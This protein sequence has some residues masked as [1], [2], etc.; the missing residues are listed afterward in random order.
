MMSF[1]AKLGRCDVVNVTVIGIARD[2]LVRPKKC[3][4]SIWLC[5]ILAIS[6]SSIDAY[7]DPKEKKEIN[8]EVAA[9]LTAFGETV[10]QYLRFWSPKEQLPVKDPVCEEL[11]G[12]V[13]LGVFDKLSPLPQQVQNYIR[14]TYKD[15]GVLWEFAPPCSG[16]DPSVERIA[17][18]AGELAKAAASY[19]YA[20]EARRDGETGQQSA[21]C[22]PGEMG[23]RCEFE[24]LD[25]PS[26]SEWLSKPKTLRLKSGLS[27]CEI[28]ESFLSVS[29]LH[30]QTTLV[31]LASFWHQAVSAA[32]DVRS[33]EDDEYVEM[34]DHD[35]KRDALVR[36]DSTR[37]LKS[38]QRALLPYSQWINSRDL[39][40]GLS[41][42]N[43]DNCTVQTSQESRDDIHACLNYA[44][45]LHPTGEEGTEQL[46]RLPDSN[47]CRNLDNPEDANFYNCSLRRDFFVSLRTAHLTGYFAKKL[48]LA[49]QNASM[50]SEAD[51]TQ[52]LQLAVSV[53]RLTPAARS[54]LP[55]DVT[56]V[57]SFSKANGE[58]LD[59]LGGND[60]IISQLKASLKAKNGLST[61][62]ENPCTPVFSYDPYW[63]DQKSQPTEPPSEK[64]YTD[65]RDWLTE[66][67]KRLDREIE[68]L[69]SVLLK[70]K[71]QYDT[72][73]DMLSVAAG[74]TAAKQELKG[75][76][77]AERAAMGLFLKT[78]AAETADTL[79]QRLGSPTEC[80][81]G[82]LDASPCQMVLHD[83]KGNPT[84]V[85]AM[86]LALQVFPAQDY[87]SAYNVSTRQL[88]TV[89]LTDDG[90]GNYAT[91][92][93]VAESRTP[94][95]V[96][97]VRGAEI[98]K[99]ITPF[100]SH[101]WGLKVIGVRAQQAGPAKCKLQ[102][103]LKRSG[104]SADSN[105]LCRAGH[106]PM[107]L[108]ADERTVWQRP[109]DPGR[110]S[111]WL[112]YLGAN[113]F[114]S[115]DGIGVTW[116]QN[117][118]ELQLFGTF[119]AT[120]LGS[121]EF[122]SFRLSLTKSSESD[123]RRIVRQASLRAV[124][125]ALPALSDVH[126]QSN[127]VPSLLNLPSGMVFGALSLDSVKPIRLRLYAHPEGHPALITAFV[128]TLDRTGSLIWRE[129][130]ALLTDKLVL[131]A[132]TVNVEAIRDLARVFTRAAGT[133][134]DLRRREQNLLGDT[135]ARRD[136]FEATFLALASALSDS[137]KD[138]TDTQSAPVDVQSTLDRYRS[139]AKA[140]QQDSAATVLLAWRASRENYKVVLDALRV[141]LE[142][143]L[144]G[145]LVVPKIPLAESLAGL[146]DTTKD[147]INKELLWLFGLSNWDEANEHINDQLAVLI[148]E[149][150]Q[151]FS[152]SGG[153]FQCWAANQEE[154]T[155]NEVGR[156][157]LC[158][159][160]QE[161]VNRIGT[162]I[163]QRFVLGFQLTSSEYDEEVER[164]RDRLNKPPA[165]LTTQQLLDAAHKIRL[166]VK[167]EAERSI[168]EA[169]AATVADIGP[170][171]GGVVGPLLTALK[172]ET[173]SADMLAALTELQINCQTSPLGCE[174][175]LVS[176]A[177]DSLYPDQ[178]AVL[179]SGLAPHLER[180][181]EALIP[182]PDVVYGAGV[183]VLTNDSRAL[184]KILTNAQSEL[185]AVLQ[186]AQQDYLRKIGNVVD[187]AGLV[188]RETIAFVPPVEVR[189]G[190]LYLR[191]S[192]SAWGGEE[193]DKLLGVNCQPDGTNCVVN[194]ENLRTDEN[195][196]TAL[197]AD[198][199]TSEA[200]SP[201][202][203]VERAGVELTLTLPRTTSYRM[204]I[205]PK[206]PGLDPSHIADVAQLVESVDPRNPAVVQENI[207]QAEIKHALLTATIGRLNEA[208]QFD[209]RTAYEDEFEAF[210]NACKAATK[211]YFLFGDSACEDPI[212]LFRK[213]SDLDLRQISTELIKN[214]ANRTTSLPRPTCTPNHKVHEV[215]QDAAKAACDELAEQVGEIEDKLISN[216]PAVARAKVAA[217]PQAV[218]QAF[219]KA[220]AGATQKEVLAT[221]L[222]VA[223]AAELLPLQQTAF[224]FKAQTER[225]CVD[226]LE[227][228]GGSVTPS[229]GGLKQRYIDA[230]NLDL[231]QIANEQVSQALKRACV[232]ASHEV[233]LGNVSNCKDLKAGLKQASTDEVKKSL[234]DFKLVRPDCSP[235]KHVGPI[236][237]SAAQSACNVLIAQL[238][239]VELAVL[240]AHFQ[241]AQN[242]TDALPRVV[243]EAFGD[244]LKQ[245]ALQAVDEAQ[246]AAQAAA[247]QA[248]HD[249]SPYWKEVQEYEQRANHLCVTTRDRAA[250]ILGDELP[251]VDGCKGIDAVLAPDVIEN[252]LHKRSKEIQQASRD[253]VETELNTRAKP[254]ID[255]AQAA[256]NEQKKLLQDAAKNQAA[257]VLAELREAESRL[258]RA[259]DKL[260]S[261][262]DTARL[263]M[264]N[265][266][267]FT[268]R[269]PRAPDAPCV[270][271]DL[272]LKT[273]MN[274]LGQIVEVTGGLSLNTDRLRDDALLDQLE[275]G[276]F[277][278]ASL[279]D[280]DWRKFRTDPS[281]ET[282]LT[283]K[284]RTL[285]KGL[286]LQRLVAGADKIQVG[287]QYQPAVL[288]FAVP[289]NTEM[290]VKGVKVELGD[291]GPTITQAVC[292]EIR[293][294]ILLEQPEILPDARIVR[295]LPAYC[296]KR[297]LKGL[298]F[299]VAVDLAEGIGRVDVQVFVDIET[300]VRIVP[301]DFKQLAA[302]QL[303]TL[304]GIDAVRPVAPFYDSTDGL[305]LYLEG[306]ADT[307]LGLALQAG[308]SVSPRRLKFR[309]PIGLRIP[310]W[311]DASV[312]SL[313][314]LGITYNPE[315]KELSLLGAL[316]VAPGEAMNNLVR[317]DGRGTVGLKEQK[318]E[319]TGNLVVLRLLGVAGTR[320]TII[321]PERLFEHT[322]GTSPMLA[323][324]V[325]LQGELHIQD[326][327]PHPFL[328]ASGEGGI[329]GADIATMEV[330][331]QRN[332]GGHFDAGLRIPLDESAVT[333]NVVVEENMGDVTAGAKT[334]LRVG[335]VKP[336]FSMDANTRSVGIGMQVEAEKIG[337]IDIGFALP[338]FASLTPE[339]VLSLLL[340][341][342]L[343]FHIPSSL[344]TVAND[345]PE[346]YSGSKSGSGGQSQG[347]KADNERQDPEPPIG[348]Y[349]PA[350]R[351][352]PVEY[353]K[354]FKIGIKLWC[355]KRIRWEP[356]FVEG[357]GGSM[358]QQAGYSASTAKHYDVHYNTTID[359]YDLLVGT[360][361]GDK[362]AYVF[363]KNGGQ[364]WA[365]T[366]RANKLAD[367]NSRPYAHKSRQGKNLL[368]VKTGGE[369]FGIQSE[370]GDLDLTNENNKLKGAKSWLQGNNNAGGFAR[371]LLP[372]V[373]EE[374][375]YHER[376]V[377][378]KPIGRPDKWVLL[379][380]TKKGDSLPSAHILAQTRG[381][382]KPL[383]FVALADLNKGMGNSTENL[384]LH[385]KALQSKLPDR[386]DQVCPPR[387]PMQDTESSLGS[388]C[389]YLAVGRWID[390]PVAL[391]L[392]DT[393]GDGPTALLATRS[394]AW[395]VPVHWPK[396]FSAASLVD[397][398]PAMLLNLM[399]SLARDPDQLDG[400]TGLTS[401]VIDLSGNG[402]IAVMGSQGDQEMLLFSPRNIQ[403]NQD[404]TPQ[405]FAPRRLNMACVEEFWA[406]KGS[407]LR[408]YEE[409]LRAERVSEKDALMLALIHHDVFKQYGFAADPVG[410]LYRKCN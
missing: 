169:W 83:S 244:T 114:V 308:F 207:Q 60:G 17:I 339:Y 77:F 280:L 47:T 98:D 370:G 310:G 233:E 396:R 172:D 111:E 260:F 342:G 82:R 347:R 41:S 305:T 237:T 372:S 80:K 97:F 246:L 364:L 1:N 189:D 181:L 160:P 369:Y 153:L 206:I 225:L 31:N 236:L 192:W 392:D 195:L 68:F 55:L 358:A 276:E 89:R 6:F 279:V 306:K 163:A 184:A 5:L 94:A 324:I 301:P 208:V 393:H 234:E 131:Y 375:I 377:E 34:S 380:I 161:A 378:Q 387:D 32:T 331:L 127:S 128:G 144:M 86:R 139:Y 348:D 404:G 316:T 340:D 382:E 353:C 329:F 334:D 245:Q 263:E 222:N 117:N 229:C 307:P 58:F 217:L 175:V 292:Q 18:I 243:A 303:L 296:I 71:K 240:D 107:M 91:P 104:D 238:D 56:K 66:S 232:E 200:P 356:A 266:A 376:T 293:D 321:L 54:W 197:S 220:F 320:T 43:L 203:R 2:K 173:N 389:A 154:N 231:R 30:E 106:A 150:L 386:L 16:I 27:R 120:A 122:E 125:K 360:E 410:S 337:S 291:L 182:R 204:A 23:K 183:E 241:R 37:R 20:L 212:A 134:E 395:V 398:D 344:A 361:A 87:D 59:A 141:D 368:V 274:L 50:Q 221:V 84:S 322:I 219:G 349:K 210:E 302:G 136:L 167:K 333:F 252:L 315:N 179:T 147:K 285:D 327:K 164:F 40:E 216:N 146:E 314:N 213:A 72:A 193:G 170:D 123:W 8:S 14:D 187:T 101:D 116:D 262:G 400:M 270:P 278:P 149:A 330:E 256:Y 188:V 124:L 309:G 13:W 151:S 199:L 38:F 251:A 319:V 132:G 176:L 338:S 374:Q 313:G 223:S 95:S 336:T 399:G 88:V 261:E 155:G 100:E 388:P 159:A 62:D 351:M 345:A 102:D 15:A 265:G 384:A 385:L 33:S 156:E 273:Q 105:R 282:V 108:R 275:A 75:R 226:A 367:L 29:C 115:A 158:G 121:S 180:T 359:N 90:C 49:Q 390:K 19:E 362:R 78:R 110:A 205:V 228:L 383:T 397:V 281:L 366:Y 26:G 36:A 401:A 174:R 317:V 230:L 168:N 191:N 381:A 290:S 46:V 242:L 312:V 335:P 235:R 287:L 343:T 138:V 311:Y 289:V 318:L 300:G 264:I 39:I 373:A 190:A 9:E 45:E 357:R 44:R 24:L 277:N 135:L 74:T 355:E 269:R 92:C 363:A 198:S 283:K 79:Y 73:R 42:L 171:A 332:F 81:M 257:P 22:A 371:R 152:A 227:S 99:N 354:P 70:Q 53:A 93:Y 271:H 140:L 57:D 284:L 325:K 326:L 394:Q 209:W 7:G 258:C 143:R 298:E 328:K 407:P 406:G 350:W 267:P 268:I 162:Q 28:S 165:P 272:S 21:V 177:L 129:P 408:P 403:T 250:D 295:V 157:T 11:T 178:A 215:L 35:M 259:I 12:K 4:M 148:V 211:A 323:D 63:I 341:M 196:K 304:F 218:T 130:R 405:Y 69:Q 64:N 48:L 103:V 255:A 51:R 365:G 286:T 145:N 118:N 52:V 253:H 391:G 224:E 76:S 214:I 352:V 137:R 202:M 247:D 201:F 194:L 249:F 346:G 409:T 248:L 133:E 85:D 61:E 288:P 402:R 119:T 185:T 299:Q 166:A 109:D 113:S 297:K 142:G 10:A 126:Q 96:L 379:A 254:L 294:Y 25:A 112:G 67:T 186:Q 239:A 65:C 3:L